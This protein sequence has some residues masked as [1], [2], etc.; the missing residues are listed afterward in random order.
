MRTRRSVSVEAI[1]QRK[2]HQAAGGEIEVPCRK[3][4][5]AALGGEEGNQV[6]RER[7]TSLNKNL[8]CNSQKRSQ[9]EKE[10]S[11]GRGNEKTGTVHHN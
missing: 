1:P 11:V 5:E 6:I 4:R 2:K 8:I 7:D 10:G 9:A 3:V